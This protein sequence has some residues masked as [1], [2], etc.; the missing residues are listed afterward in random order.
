MKTTK[1]SRRLL[2]LMLAFIMALAL[3]PASQTYANNPIRVTVNGQMVT[4]PD[5]QPVMI[6]NRVLVPVS[7]VFELMGYTPSWDPDTR[8]ARL[9]RHDAE[10]IIPAASS[11]FVVTRTVNNQV[12]SVQHTPEVPQRIINN[13]LMLP[14]R[15]V[16]DALGALP[17]TWDGTNRVAHIVTGTAPTPTPSPTPTP[18]PAATPVP[19]VVGAPRFEGSTGFG[20]GGNATMGGEIFE[21]SIFGGGHSQHRLDRNFATLTGYIGR[22]DLSGGAARYIRIIGDGELLHSQRVEG[23]TFNRIP[24]AL[25][26][27]NITTLRIE[28]DEVGAGGVSVVFGR[29]NLH[30]TQATAPIPTPRPTPTPAATPAPF[31]TTRI[32]GAQG[33]A[34][35]GNTAHI[36]GTAHANSIVGGGWSLH[37]LNNQFVTFSGTIGRLDGTGWEPRTVRIYADNVIRHTQVVSGTQFTPIPFSLDVRNVST[38]RIEA[39]HAGA[40]GVTIAIGNPI[41]HRAVP[42]TTPT[43]SPT[44]TPPPNLATTPAPLLTAVPPTADS[45]A[46]QNSVHVAGTGATQHNV[47]WGGTSTH[48]LNGRWATLTGSFGRLEGSGAHQ[49]TVRVYADNV[50]RQSLVVTGSNFTPQ[51]F[52]VDVRNVWRLD[53]VMEPL[54]TSNANHGAVAVVYDTILHPVVTATPT[55]TPSPTPTAA[56]LQVAAPRLN[57]EGHLAFGNIGVV[58]MH[59][60]AT[61]QPNSM[62]GSTASTHRLNNRFT[63]LTVTIGRQA[64][65]TGTNSAVRIVNVDTGATLLNVTVSNDFTHDT[66]VLNVTGVNLLRIEIQDPGADGIT[67]VLGNITVQ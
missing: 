49:R 48:H 52:T 27:R 32:D 22:L 23:Y 59:G 39:E 64:G 26:V 62:W 10:V 21:N 58:S 30:P 57:D 1:P 33:F 63:T 18:T 20:L 47:L 42:G 16:A 67:A 7:G 46:L 66:Q 60:I 61:P 4:F 54:A 3:V 65:S 41:L 44:P 51:T 43:P 12:T 37:H 5:Q 11:S 19:L 34:V 35:A 31:V 40:N 9:T 55:P 14:L 50:Y 29:I 36:N 25:D 45:T 56:A 15:A 6:E 38:I 2:V 8:I 24:V 13:R 53:I 28:I 17:P